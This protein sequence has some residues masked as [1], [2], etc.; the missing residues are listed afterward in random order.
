MVPRDVMGNMSINIDG[1]FCFYASMFVAWL[2]D[3]RCLFTLFVF[4]ESAELEVFMN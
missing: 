3:G 2:C 4:V 1:E